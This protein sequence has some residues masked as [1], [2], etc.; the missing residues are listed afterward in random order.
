MDESS[1]LPQVKLEAMDKLAS[2]HESSADVE[3]AEALYLR[4]LAWREGA[5]QFEVGQ[6]DMVR[7]FPS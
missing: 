7:P 2:A 1:P 5:D 3:R 6:W 4:M